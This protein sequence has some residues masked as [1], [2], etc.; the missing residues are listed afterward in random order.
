[1]I[2]PT[3]KQ[4]VT[5][6]LTEA[7]TVPVYEV[8]TIPREHTATAIATTE[9]EVVVT[10]FSTVVG[11]A[12]TLTSQVAVPGTTRTVVEGTTAQQEPIET[13]P[14]TT[15]TTS[16]PAEFTGAAVANKP[17]YVALGALAGAVA[18]L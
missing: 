5:N 9:E 15:P 10:Y 8:T 16:A 6:V 7:E 13:T 14:T 17:G 18:F 12:P 4:T 2:A 1:M 11:P 3:T